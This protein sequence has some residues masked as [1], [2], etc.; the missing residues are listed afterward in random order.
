MR[1]RSRRPGD[2]RCLG[3]FVIAAGNFF[4]GSDPSQCPEDF[5]QR[6]AVDKSLRGVTNRVQTLESGELTLER[7]AAILAETSKV[8][9][10]KGFGEIFRGHMECSNVRRV[11]GGGHR[12]TAKP[13]VV[14]RRIAAC[15]REITGVIS[16]LSSLQWA[17]S[18]PDAYSGAIAYQ[19][20]KSSTLRKSDRAVELA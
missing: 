16:P 12:R 4:A 1:E 2:R 13:R 7:N 14:R 3:R 20:R 6:N 15:E 17:R 18:R 10:G 5:G 9:G 11:Y 19:I 8:G